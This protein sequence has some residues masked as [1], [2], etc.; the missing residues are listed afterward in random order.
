MCKN[1]PYDD[2]GWCCL[3]GGDIPDD[4]ECYDDDEDF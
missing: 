2:D 4:A 3:E 1:C